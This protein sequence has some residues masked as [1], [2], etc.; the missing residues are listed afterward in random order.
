MSEMNIVLAVNCR[1][2]PDKV[3]A[4]MEIL[5]ANAKAARETEPGCLHFDVNVDKED[6]TKIMYYEVYRDQAAIDAHAQTAHHKR[7]VTEGAPML[8]VREPVKLR[9]AAP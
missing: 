9:R 6:P 4:L 8:A 7:W 1:I 5:L 3:D 2:E